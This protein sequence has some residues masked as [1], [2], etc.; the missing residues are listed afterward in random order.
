[1]GHEFEIPLKVNLDWF[2][3]SLKSKLDFQIPLLD[4]GSY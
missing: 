3:S 2:R 1:M 4:L